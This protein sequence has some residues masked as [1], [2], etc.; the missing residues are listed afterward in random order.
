MQTS[1]FSIFNLFSRLNIFVW[2]HS[3]K[4][5]TKHKATL[6]SEFPHLHYCFIPFGTLAERPFKKAFS[7]LNQYRKGRE[8]QSKCVC[9]NR[10]RETK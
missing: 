6:F 4:I 10:E 1:K 3:T 7:S 9:F 8:F 2:L 5:K